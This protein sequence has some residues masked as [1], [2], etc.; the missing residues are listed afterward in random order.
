MKLL[1]TSALIAVVMTA[2]S[3]S[4]AAAHAQVNKNLYSQ[5]GGRE[6]RHRCGPG[7]GSA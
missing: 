6:C 2:A 1:V 3:L 5:T 7:A 4:P